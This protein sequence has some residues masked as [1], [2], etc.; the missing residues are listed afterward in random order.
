MEQ[1]KVIHH[2]F[3]TNQYYQYETEKS[4]IVIHHTV[5]GDSVSGDIKWWEQTESRIA[6][7]IIIA[8]DGTIHT[9]FKSENW[10]HHLGVR[11]KVFDSIGVKRKYRKSS[12]TGRL[13]VSNNIEL[14][15]GS[16]GVEL[17][18]W[19]GLKKVGDK[20]YTAATNKEISSDKVVDYGEEI[21]GYRYYEKYTEEQIYSLKFLLK[22]WNDKYEIPLDY[23]EDMWDLSK[24]ALTGEPGVWTHTSYRPD[25]SDCHPQTELIEMLKSL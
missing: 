17:D 16:I 13:F 1:P 19:G 6:T 18:S 8:R 5:S 22:Y 23:K 3:P 12:K 2:E 7:C 21:R 11:I 20:F 25:K 9:L 24:G 15:E 14:N 4:Q 10:A